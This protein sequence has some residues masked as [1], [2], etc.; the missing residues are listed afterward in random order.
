PGRQCLTQ[1][2]PADPAHHV[3]LGADYGLVLAVR[4]RLRGKRVDGMQARQDA[5]LAPHVVRALDFA[6]E[7]RP[8]QPLLL[9]TL[10]QQVREIRVT[11]RK[12]LDAERPSSEFGQCLPEPFGEP[13]G[14]EQLAL[15]YGARLVD[16][17]HAPCP[18]TSS[19]YCLRMRRATTDL[20]T[21]S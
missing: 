12:L 9:R 16:E 5:I 19:P 17:R 13:L 7:R 18:P 21:S 20:C 4:D 2:D 11:A 8:A 3:K 15:A 6:A 10:A 14:V 1:N